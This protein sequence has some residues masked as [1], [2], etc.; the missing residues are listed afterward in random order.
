MEGGR[1]EVEEK[2]IVKGVG[3]IAATMDDHLVL[4]EVGHMVAAR[5]WCPAL[6]MELGQLEWV[7]P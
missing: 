2:E 1:T 3:A 6:R 7:I 5:P 4:D